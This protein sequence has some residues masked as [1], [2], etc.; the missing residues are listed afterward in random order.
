MLSSK[1]LGLQLPEPMMCAVCRVVNATGDGFM[2]KSGKAS[3]KAGKAGLK[4]GAGAA[5]VTGKAAGTVLKGVGAV[6]S[7]VEIFSD[8]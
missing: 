6:L 5:K 3:L 1:Q 2:T 4:A 7:V 8:D